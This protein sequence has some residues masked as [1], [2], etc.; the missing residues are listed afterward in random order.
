MMTTATLKAA[1]AN[2]GVAQLMAAHSPL[3]AVLA[4]EAGFDGVWVSGFEQA[5]L[6]GL[7]D[8]S[9]QGLSDRLAL[10]QR[11]QARTDLPVVVD[12]DTGFGNALNAHHTAAQ[13]ARA[14][15]AAIV[16]EDQVFPKMTSLAAGVS[17][18][19]APIDDAQSRIAAACAARAGKPMLVI[20]R[21]EA[22]IANATLDEAVERGAAY[23]E[24]GADLLF[25]HSKHTTSAQ[26]E[27]FADVWDK[28]VGLVVAPTSYPAF[29]PEEARK[30]GKIQIVIHANHA[31]RAAI[32]GMQSAFKRIRELG[33]LAAEPHLASVAE[34]MRLQDMEEIKRLERQFARSEK[35]EL[36]AERT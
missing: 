2:R 32:A 26:I 7:A 12:A 34:V 19:L 22:L 13:F 20:A 11:I 14:G 10:T 5:A 3:S 6:E 16:I 23:V 30:I 24:A 25:V 36:R 9:F 31:I 33:A 15:A 18:Q 35:I 8:A 1:I 21:T 17:H 4:G 28:N 27:A 29:G